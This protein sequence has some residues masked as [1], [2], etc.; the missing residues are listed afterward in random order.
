[1]AA[2]STSYHRGVDYFRRLGESLED[3]WLCAGRHEEIFP[4]VA[5]DVLSKLPSST[6][7]DRDA[8][9]DAVLGR[10]GSATLQLAP[11]EAFAQPGI[12]MFH[13]DGFVVEVY[14]WLSSV[15]AIHNHPFCGAFTVLEG[16]SVHARYEVS[17]LVPAGGRALV[18]E[19]SLAELERLEAG[20]VRL[21]SLVRHPLVHALIHVPVPSISM[22]VRTTRTEG[23]LRYLPPA[24]VLPMEAPG[25]PL[26][27]QLALVHA[28]GRANDP[29]HERA[30]ASMLRAADFETAVRLLS[31]I[32]PGSDD[33]EGWLD[34]LR[35][36]LGDGVDTI[37]RSLDRALRQNEANRLREQLHDPELR[38]VA[39]ALMFAERREHV[40]SLL[41]G[42]DPQALL[43]RFI[44]SPAVFA[45]DEAAS[46]VIAT[47][48]VKG[49][50]EAGA[51]KRLNDAYGESVVTEQRGNITRYCD[52]SIFSP[53]GKT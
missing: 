22:V 5:R 36:R 7:F 40:F 31:P 30:L 23:Y 1:M 42:D 37:A 21:F 17:S 32:W 16:H 46:A 53:L 9:V 50:G 28:M 38:L 24:V 35:P 49:E 52:R 8:F 3:T 25:D 12:T 13:G 51:L 29:A 33:A 41:N 18:G 39:T 14:Y 20:E 48:L 44:A 34:E 4:E 15:S 2:D 11:P 6:G 19:V 10:R 43:E 47:A 45:P 27:R 26:A